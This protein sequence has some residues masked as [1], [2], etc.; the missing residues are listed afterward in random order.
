MNRAALD[1]LTIGYFILMGVLAGANFVAI[2]FTLKDLAPFW[3]A[4]VRFLPASAVLFIVCLLRR[5]MLPRG[6]SLAGAILFG[7]LNF[8]GC[9][10]FLY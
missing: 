10:S 5:I 4:A 9:F 8:A 7:T 3:S 6:K 2:R 1:F